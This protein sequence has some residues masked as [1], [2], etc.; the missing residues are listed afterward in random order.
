ME[1]LNDND[2][3]KIEIDGF[4][5]VLAFFYIDTIGGII[6]RTNH[7]AS[8]GRYE[9]TSAMQTDLENMS[10][11]QQYCVQ[12]L[13]KFGID[14]ESAKNR[15]DGDYWKWFDH[16]NSW[17]DN[18]SN[19]EWMAFDIKMSNNEDLTDFL[20]KHKWNEE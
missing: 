19:E 12:T 16:W 2:A 7:D 10:K 1:N 5:E 20:P 18:M 9:I 6:W 3:I 4:S 17:R 13:T 8:H 14:P 11:L 15:P